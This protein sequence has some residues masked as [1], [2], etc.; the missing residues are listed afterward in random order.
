MSP[1]TPAARIVEALGLAPHPEGGWFKET[2][3]DAAGEGERAA[4][5]AISTL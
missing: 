3:R 4:S 1:D 5:T 2:F